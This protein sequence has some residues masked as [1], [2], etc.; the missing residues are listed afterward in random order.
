M[1]RA[2]TRSGWV[3]LGHASA[4]VLLPL[5]APAPPPPFPSPPGR[6]F[7]RAK[8]AIGAMGAMGAMAVLRLL[9]CLCFG[10]C[11]WLSRSVAGGEEITKGEL[12]WSCSFPKN[13]LSLCFL[14]FLVVPPSVIGRVQT[15]ALTEA[16]P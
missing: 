6:R 15:R 1:L 3:V 12:G 4:F 10:C 5:S 8:V 16:V 13:Q 9:Y 11:W 14:S 7:P 2:C